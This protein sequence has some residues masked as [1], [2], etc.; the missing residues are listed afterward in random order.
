MALLHRGSDLPVVPHFERG[1]PAARSVLGPWPLKMGVS[2]VESGVVPEHVSRECLI[3]WIS[4][5]E[6][7]CAVWS[8]VISFARRVV[9]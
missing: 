2:A 3:P 1:L 6:R 5:R 8:K 4:L 7:E 9:C